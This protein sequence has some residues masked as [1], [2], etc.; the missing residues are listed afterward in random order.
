MNVVKLLKNRICYTC[1][2]L[3]EKNE[4]FSDRGE[5]VSD[6]TRVSIRDTLIEGIIEAL[7]N[8]DPRELERQL[9][10]IA[11]ISSRAVEGFTLE[12]LK[13]LEDDQ[14][15]GDTSLH[16]ADLRE[17]LEAVRPFG[18]YWYDI[19]E[20]GDTAG[21]LIDGVDIYE[22]QRRIFNKIDRVLQMFE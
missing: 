10:M 13:N 2:M 18:R 15:L 7:D 21:E 9:Q 14:S 8:K 1:S 17:V 3:A 6:E 5:M 22:R 4:D 20:L 16:K 12:A 19:R 11:D